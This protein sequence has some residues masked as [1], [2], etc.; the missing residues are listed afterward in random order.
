MR[1][2]SCSSRAG[3]TRVPRTH[4]DSVETTA[5]SQAPLIPV[6]SG[7]LTAATV[8]AAKNV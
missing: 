6:S 3:A 2:S 8:M 5:R 4:S 7:G 1:M